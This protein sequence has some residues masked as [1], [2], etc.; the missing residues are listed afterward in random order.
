MALHKKRV[1]FITMGVITLVVFAGILALLFNIKAFKPQI[2]AAASTALGMDVQIKG[3]MGIALFPSFGL[4]VKDVNVGNRE[5]NVV[6]IKKIKMGLKP[7]R[8][9]PA[10]RTKTADSIMRPL[11]IM[12]KR[13]RN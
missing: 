8:A 11:D 1:L 12:K 5:S 3:R 6:T 10:I 13:L 4:S 9:M 2:E 7:F